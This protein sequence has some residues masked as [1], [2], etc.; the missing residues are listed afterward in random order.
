VVTV[1]NELGEPRYPTAAR[2]MAARRMQPQ[3]LTT[4]T[5]GLTPDDVT[6]RVLLERMFVPAA[7]G[8]CEFIAGASAAA[9]A[10]ELVARLR[11]ER[12]I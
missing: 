12:L 11:S 1:S 2:S 4:D 6:P 8:T 5:L 3:E 7:Q 10:T 9:V